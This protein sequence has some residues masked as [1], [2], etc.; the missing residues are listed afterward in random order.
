MRT[1]LL[2][3]LFANLVV[4]LLLS[5]FGAFWWWMTGGDIEWTLL[6]TLVSWLGIVSVATVITFWKQR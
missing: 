1:M 6:F 5:A 4:A 2:W 3:H